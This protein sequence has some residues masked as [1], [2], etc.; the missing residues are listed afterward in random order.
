MTTAVLPGDDCQRLNHP[1]AWVQVSAPGDNIQ[2]CQVCTFAR[3]AA[4][5]HGFDDAG[6]DRFVLY[7]RRTTDPYNPQEETP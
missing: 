3:L 4:L 7:L 2:I 6:A 1:A 5:T